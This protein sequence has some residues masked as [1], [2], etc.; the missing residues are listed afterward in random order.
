MSQS[1]KN[2]NGGGEGFGLL[3]LF[4]SALLVV[5]A[6]FWPRSP[7][8][9][10]GSRSVMVGSA[11]QN[12]IS[13]APPNV[14]VPPAIVNRINEHLKDAEIKEEMQR[15]NANIDIQS[16]PPLGP[17]DE[18]AVTIDQEKNAI[19]PLVLDQENRAARAIQEPRS[20]SSSRLP[21]TSDQRIS[22]QL[23]K[24]Q[25]TRDYDQKYKEEY[26][27]QFIENA[28]K[29]G[30]DVK[31]NKDLD[32]TGLRPLP[33]EEPLRIPQSEAPPNSSK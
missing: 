33:S 12:S 21:P 29:S 3:L 25:W 30:L 26:V 17:I 10:P 18:D 27:R 31:V 28:R 13:S 19:N 14:P 1:R 4:L 8:F 20:N 9:G 7:N 24:E 32:V 23:A 16:S 6:F 5:A 15:Q 2:S 11:E 22:S